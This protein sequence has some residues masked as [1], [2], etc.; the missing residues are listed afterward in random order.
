MNEIDENEKE[1]T[2]LMCGYIPTSCKCDE[3]LEPTHWVSCEVISTVGYHD[4]HEVGDVIQVD[5]KHVDE[6]IEKGFIRT[7][8]CD[9]V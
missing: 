8:G 3:E 6:M 9:Y 7:I 1:K 5:S 2:C 4:T